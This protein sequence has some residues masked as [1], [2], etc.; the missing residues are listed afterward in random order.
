MPPSLPARPRSVAVVALLLGLMVVAARCTSI[1]A[2][3]VT[4]EQGH[5]LLPRRLLA[6]GAVLCTCR[7]ECGWLGQRD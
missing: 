7:Q 6:A 1:D 2:A 4:A 3:A 5:S